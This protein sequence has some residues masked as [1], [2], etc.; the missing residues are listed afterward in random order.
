MKRLLYTLLFAIFGVFSII[1]SCK[2]DK[3]EDPVPCTT[4]QKVSEAKDYFAFKV[5]TWWVYEEETSLARDSVYVTESHFNM[6]GYAEYD[7]DVRMFSTYQNFYYHYWPMFISNLKGCNVINPVS[8]RCLYVK[9]SKYQ[10]GNFI[11]ESKCFFVAYK[12]GDFIYEFNVNYENNK[13]F[14]KQVLS[15]YNLNGQ[16]FGKTVKIH[17]LCTFIEGN[18]PTN[19]YFSKGVGLIRKELIDSNQVWNLVNYHIEP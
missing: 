1:T 10:F 18:Q 16:M 14:I 11:G 12:T 6:T 19:H 13:V 17:E 8:N 2:K 7:F 4:C 9:R 15:E 5:G 3:P